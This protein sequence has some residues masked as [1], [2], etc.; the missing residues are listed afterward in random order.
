MVLHVTLSNGPAKT[1]TVIID[2]NQLSSGNPTATKNTLQ[3][4][5]KNACPGVNFN[6]KFEKANSGI[7][8]LS[9]NSQVKVGSNSLT[10]GKTY[11]VIINSN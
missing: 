6:F 9:P 8:Y 2:A 1:Y 7:G 10:Q 5:L 3:T 11:N 4:K